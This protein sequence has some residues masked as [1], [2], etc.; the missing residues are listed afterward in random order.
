[1]EMLE[2]IKTNT[3][4]VENRNEIALTATR[5][6]MELAEKSI[7]EKGAFDVAISGGRS[8]I[9][10]YNRVAG[11]LLPSGIDWEKIH[12]FWVDERCV[13]PD[14]E[15]S[16]Y[17]LAFDSLVSKIPIPADNVHRMAGEVCD[18]S[19]AVQEYESIIRDH[20]EISE[21][22]FPVFDLISLGMGADGHI[23]SLFP[24]SNT[25]FDTQDIVAPVYMM[26]EKLNRITLTVPVLQAARNLI[27]IISGKE[28][29]KAVRNVF[30]S[31]EDE[32]QYPV[33]ALWPVLDRVN[34]IL[35]R[36]AAVLLDI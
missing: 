8:P 23:A 34:W 29:A 1:M 24:N 4:V 6:F 7:A 32:I 28:K 19:L 12:I 15:H 35:D 5:L 36:E 14:S 16:N 33:H 31:E 22:E 2:Q 10:F 25:L 30:C 21:G 26:N 17:K 18:Y 3:R 20:F 27:V 13:S 11:T 9:E